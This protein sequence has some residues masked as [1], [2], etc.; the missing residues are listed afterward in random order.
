VN[1][2]SFN[3]AIENNPNHHIIL[4]LRL[5]TLF[6]FIFLIIVVLFDYFFSN[7]EPMFVYSIRPV[8]VMHFMISILPSDN[9]VERTR[10]FNAPSGL[11]FFFLFSFS[12]CIISISL[13]A[14]SQT[15]HLFM[16]ST[17]FEI[18]IYIYIYI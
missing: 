18:V 9:I 3:T 8:N 17:G 11:L 14:N 6:Y 7:A 16:I 15:F 1:G 12:F 4:K 2:D 10:L 5:M 13:Q